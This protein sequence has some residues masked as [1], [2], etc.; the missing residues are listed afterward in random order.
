MDWPGQGSRDRPGWDMQTSNAVEKR[1]YVSGGRGS[2]SPERAVGERQLS[3]EAGS[4]RGAYAH[5]H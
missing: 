4:L 5:A 1:K 3:S 2:D